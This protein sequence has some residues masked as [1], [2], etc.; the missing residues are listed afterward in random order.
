MIYSV[1]T[2]SDDIQN[3]FISLHLRPGVYFRSDN[4]L[5]HDRSREYFT[6]ALVR[7]DSY[8]LICGMG[9]PVRVDERLVSGIKRGDKNVSAGE[10]C[11]KS[12]CEGTVL[13]CVLRSARDIIL[14]EAEIGAY[15]QVFNF[16]LVRGKG[17]EVGYGT[18]AK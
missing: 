8:L 11:N 5:L 3:L 9:K 13:I 17:S 1:E 6:C 2:Q 15:R 4:D 18:P 7:C 12:S 14:L 10:W 16:R